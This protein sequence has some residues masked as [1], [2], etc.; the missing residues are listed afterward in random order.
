MELDCFI[1]RRKQIDHNESGKV[2]EVDGVFTRKRN[3]LGETVKGNADN[4]ELKARLYLT[5]C[6]SLLGMLVF[7]VL[8]IVTGA[9]LMINIH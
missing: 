9:L 5:V 2:D 4:K 8:M 1:A 6:C 7:T 3:T